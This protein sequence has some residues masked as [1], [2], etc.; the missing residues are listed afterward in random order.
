MKTFGLVHG[1]FHGPW[2]WERLVP[3]LEGLGHRVLTVDLPCEDPVAGAAEYAATALAAFAD[4][5][6]DLVVVGHSLGGLTIPLIAAAR[7][8]RQLIFLETIIPR[9]GKAHEEVLRAE[10][11]MILPSPEGATS[12]GPDGVNQF[13]PEAAVRWFFA[14]CPP[15]LGAWAASRLRGQASK[16]NVEMTPLP[17]WPATP[18]SYVLGTRDPVVNPAWSRR[19]ARSILGVEPVEIDAGHSPFLA[20]PGL[21]AKTLDDISGNSSPLF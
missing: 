13:R 17:A 12:A 14:D 5:G 4:A 6:E 18:C 8:V 21:L 16:I 1:A 15:E 11:D 9:P 10:P 19:A 2:C 3:E 7:P 20:I